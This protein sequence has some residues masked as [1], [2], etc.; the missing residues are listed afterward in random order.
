MRTPCIIIGAGIAGIMAGRTLQAAGLNPILLDKGQSIGGRMATRWIDQAIFDHGAQY[1]TA[2]A[3]CTSFS[4]QVYQLEAEG[5]VKRWKLPER[6]IGTL[7]MNA[8][9]QH[10]GKP[11]DCRP[12][13]RV[14]AVEAQSDHWRIQTD[15]GETFEANSLLMTPPLP[16]TLALLDGVG[17][18]ERLQYQLGQVHFDPCLVLLAVPES[19]ITLKPEGQ[20]AESILHISDNHEKGISPR[21]QALTIQAAPAFSRTWYDAPDHEIAE[22]LFEASG[23]RTSTWQIKRWRYSRCAQPYSSLYSQSFVLTQTPL[24][25]ALA[26]DSYSESRVEAAACSGMDAAQALLSLIR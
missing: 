8:V 12:R 7:G 11:L 13:T 26:G 1:F 3:P 23:L 24:P 25:L 16:Q 20:W 17:L 14:V 5:V 9:A 4:A 6:I 2:Q 15:V 19:P 21:Q 18:S 22:Q 10:L